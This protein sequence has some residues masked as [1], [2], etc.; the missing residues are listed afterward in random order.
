[1]SRT[2]KDIIAEKELFQEKRLERIEDKLDDIMSNHLPHIRQDIAKI[3]TELRYQL[4]I[5]LVILGAIAGA[6]AQLLVG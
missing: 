1:M 3:K 2:V 6:L 4:A 5:G